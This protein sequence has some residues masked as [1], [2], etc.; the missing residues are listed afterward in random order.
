MTGWLLPRNA[1]SFARRTIATIIVIALATVTVD[2][3]RGPD[4]PPEETHA[5]SN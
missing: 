3:C 4:T 1:G 5:R 2:A